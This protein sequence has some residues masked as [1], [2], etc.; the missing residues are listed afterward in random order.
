MTLTAE[1]IAG[2]NI[3][4]NEAVLRGIELDQPGRRFGMTLAV[5]SLPDDDAPQPDDPR[6]AITLEGVGRVAVSW[7]HARWD[8]RRAPAIPLSVEDLATTVDSFGQ[9]SI[10]GWKFIDAGDDAFT[11][12]ERRLSL[13]VRLGAEGKHTFDMFQDDGSH[14]IEL[15]VWFSTISFR[16]IDPDGVPFP[17]VI[18]RVI[19]DGRRWW[20]AMHAGDPRTAASGIARLPPWEPPPALSQR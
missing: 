7:R 15:R 19:A 6:L 5:L 10:Y 20:D 13:D 18:G 1:H 3:A 16:R 8:D 14:F 2:L 12:A 4:F 11:D 17:V 9:Q